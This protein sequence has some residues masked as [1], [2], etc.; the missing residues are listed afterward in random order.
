M[1]RAATIPAA[2]DSRDVSL[3]FYNLFKNNMKRSVKNST[4]GQLRF[5]WKNRE[6]G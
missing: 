3:L 4:A 2:M 1:N 6:T 5:L